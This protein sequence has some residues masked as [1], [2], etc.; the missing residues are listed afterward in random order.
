M[1]LLQVRLALRKHAER[2]FKFV[3]EL[4]EGC[5]VKKLSSF[6]GKLFPEAEFGVRGELRVGEE[7]NDGERVYLD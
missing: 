7:R 2:L 6:G 5:G 4:A 3:V 1:S